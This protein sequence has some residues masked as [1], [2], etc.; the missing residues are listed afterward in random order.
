MAHY[1]GIGALGIFIVIHLLAMIVTAAYGPLIVGAAPLECAGIPSFA[2]GSPFQDI[3]VTLE[4]AE[5]FGVVGMIGL[6]RS[7]LTLIF[8]ILAVDY[9]ILKGGG[10]LASGFG[11]IVRLLGWTMI[12]SGV[13]ALGA[14]LFGR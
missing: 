4:G 11:F 2:C 6:F 12:A 3:A 7:F 13:V 10:E 5:G 14:Q 9:D 8:G 1:I